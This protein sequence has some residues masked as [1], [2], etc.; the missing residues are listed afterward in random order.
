MLDR[1]LRVNLR[2]RLVAFFGL[3]DPWQRP[4]PGIGRGDFLLAAS[5]EVFGLVMLELVLNGGG[6][7]DYDTLVC[8][9]V[10][11]ISTGAVLLM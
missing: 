10:L 7:D 4:R 1:P 3:D 8:A 6:F 5:V 9:M 11:G 2:E